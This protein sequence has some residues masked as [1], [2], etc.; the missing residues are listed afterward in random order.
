MWI[1]GIVA[2]EVGIKTHAVQGAEVPLIDENLL[3][4]A[5]IKKAS[6]CTAL[7]EVLSI[8]DAKRMPY[9]FLMLG[10][11]DTMALSVTWLAVSSQAIFAFGGAVEMLSGSRPCLVTM[12]TPFDWTCAERE[13]KL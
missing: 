7:L 6:S 9:M 12:G 10:N 13:G 8:P 1:V 4:M 5:R 11:P 3:A 2:A